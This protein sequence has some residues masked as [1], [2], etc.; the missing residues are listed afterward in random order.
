[1]TRTHPILLHELV[2]ALDAAYRATTMHVANPISFSTFGTI[3]NLAAWATAV[4]FAPIPR[5][6]K[7]RALRDF[8]SFAIFNRPWQC[9]D[10]FI[11]VRYVIRGE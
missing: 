8:A 4:A 11:V 1:M 10:S 2:T 7:A 3:G 6:R 9:T 5:L